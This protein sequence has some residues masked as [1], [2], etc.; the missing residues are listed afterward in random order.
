MTV[1]NWFSASNLTN[2]YFFCIVGYE[3]LSVFSLIW[4][5]NHEL[6]WKMCAYRIY[7]NFKSN[8]PQIYASIV[9][10]FNWITIDIIGKRLTHATLCS[11]IQNSN[12]YISNLI[13]WLHFDCILIAFC[14]AIFEYN[15][16]KCSNYMMGYSSWSHNLI[17]ET[18]SKLF[19]FC[20]YLKKN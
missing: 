18:E 12:S 7:K 2:V 8:L 13:M 6:H 17:Y 1:T 19:S 11:A 20:L 5:F 3:L 10:V 14:N 4:I 15:W 16:C 9:I